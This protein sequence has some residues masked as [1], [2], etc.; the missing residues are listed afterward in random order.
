MAVNWVTQ[1]FRRMVKKKALKRWE[2]KLG[3]P[4]VIPQALW[5]TGN[6]SWKGADQRHHDKVNIIA[7]CLGNQNTAHVL[8]YSDR[9][10]HVE[11]KVEALLAIVEED[12]PVNFWPCSVLVPVLYILYKIDVPAA[13]GTYLGLLVDNAYNYTKKHQCCVLCK[14][15]CGLPTVKLCGCWKIK[16]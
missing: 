6:C 14:L 5:P 9:R 10:P 8:C 15:Q 1:H 16:D 12:I 7:N 3:N 11:A 2:T 4:K 13:H